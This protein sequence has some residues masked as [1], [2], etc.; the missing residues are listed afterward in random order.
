MA[1]WTARRWRLLSKS[2]DTAPDPALTSVY[3]KCVA[4]L[5]NPYHKLMETG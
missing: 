4:E 3:D 1:L 2:L 5:E